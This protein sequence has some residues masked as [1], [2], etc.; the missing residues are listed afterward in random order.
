MAEKQKKI[1]RS[2]K[3]NQKKDTTPIKEE[4]FEDDISAYDED[5]HKKRQSLKR[6][7][8][9]ADAQFE[10]D[11]RVDDELEDDLRNIEE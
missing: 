4:D 11:E 5:Q 7:E 1:N 2:T 10:R 3:K 6:N 9:P 8:S